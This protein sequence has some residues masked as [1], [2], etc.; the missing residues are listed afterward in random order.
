MTENHV[1]QPPSGSLQLAGHGAVTQALVDHWK[2]QNAPRAIVASTSAQLGPVELSAVGQV[3]RPSGIPS[4]E[5]FGTPS[6]ESLPDI[7]IPAG[8]VVLGDKTSE[9]RLVDAVGIAWFEIIKQLSADPDY[10]YNVNWRTLEEVVAGAYEREGFQ[11]VLTSRSG[12]KGRDVIA[13]KEGVGAIRIIDQVKALGRGQ[14]VELDD[15]RAM[16]GVLYRDT[17]VSK[18]VITTTTTFP[19]STYD[20]FK[21]FI[22]NRLELKPGP[23]L[24]DWLIALMKGQGRGVRATQT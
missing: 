20:E 16:L 4:E 2:A 22:P 24:R 3:I 13:S 17:N 23:I 8:V 7:I 11:V 18:A 14:R 6:I 12:D 21:N 15:V 5:A 1:V 19:P 10:L 9:G